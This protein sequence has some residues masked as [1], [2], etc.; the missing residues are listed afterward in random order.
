MRLPYTV[1][2]YQQAG[3][4]AVGEI[5]NLPGCTQVAVFHSAWVSPE[6]RGKGYGEQAH[7]LRLHEATGMLYDYA[8]C[9]VDAKN[10]RQISLL[11]K[12]GWKCLDSFI[13]TKTGHNVCIYG[14]LLTS[15][16]GF[17]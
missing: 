14:K 10:E 4:V 7:V 9:T 1:A 13:S 5:D 2:K 11:T 17:D 15:K 6:Y 12:F 16:G 3:P 8:L